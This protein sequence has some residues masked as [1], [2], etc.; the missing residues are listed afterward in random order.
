MAW[1]SLDRESMK[2]GYYPARRGRA[3]GEALQDRRKGKKRQKGRKSREVE[4]TGEGAG[5]AR[6]SNIRGEL[7]TPWRE[8]RHVVAKG[9]ISA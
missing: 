5:V 9:E 2:G 7:S 3:K 8:Y 6:S 1:G 4:Q